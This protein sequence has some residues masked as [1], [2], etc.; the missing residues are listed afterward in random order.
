MH[1]GTCFPCLQVKTFVF[2]C[3][4]K[5]KRSDTKQR[6][7]LCY[8]TLGQYLTRGN[9][10]LKVCGS[11]CE[12]VKVG[13][14][15]SKTKSVVPLFSNSSR[16]NAWSAW[17]QY[18]TEVDIRKCV[19]TSP[20][21]SCDPGPGRIIMRGQLKMWNVEWKPVGASFFSILFLGGGGSR[22]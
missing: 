10:T 18:A 8:M 17:T 7:R 6:L 12:M 2:R 1:A 11:L 15:G 19:E 16:A 20:V 9:T 13:K 3:F 21:Y 14:M 22:L 4:V 5:V